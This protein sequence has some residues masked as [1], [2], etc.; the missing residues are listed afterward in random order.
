MNLKD[1][2]QL[3]A[4]RRVAEIQAELASIRRVFPELSSR[5]V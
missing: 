2:A 5:R 4:T 1:L 3:G